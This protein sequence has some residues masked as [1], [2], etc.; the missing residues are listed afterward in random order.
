[1]PIRIGTPK[2]F[3][4]S[5]TLNTGKRVIPVIPL[6]SGII[7][8]TATL[9]LLIKAD[10]NVKLMLTVLFSGILILKAYYRWGVLEKRLVAHNDLRLGIGKFDAITE[11][12]T[13]LPK[14]VLCAGGTGARRLINN[15]LRFIFKHR[16]GST[17]PFE[18]L[19]FHA[20]NNKDPKGF[21]FEQLIRV[22]SQQIAPIYHQDMV[23]SVKILPGTLNEGLQTLKQSTKIEEI[24]I[25]HSKNLKED[26]EFCAELESELEIKVSTLY[27]K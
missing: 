26:E 1:M 17:Q 23:L 4:S 6:V 11:I 7:L 22:V 27:K 19:V 8:L 18:L 13:D 16:S 25:G 2:D 12:P 10:E 3:L 21:F 24:F 14:F 5:W 9:T 20:E 15:C